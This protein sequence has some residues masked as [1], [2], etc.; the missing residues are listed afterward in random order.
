MSN[1]E[2]IAKNIKDE[3]EALLGYVPLLNDSDE[4]IREVVGEIV[5]DELNHLLMLAAIYSKITGIKPAKDGLSEA[6]AFRKPIPPMADSAIWSL[7]NPMEGLSTS[8]F[9]PVFFCSSCETCDL[10]SVR[11]SL[12]AAVAS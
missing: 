6:L 8:R 2:E 7:P 3:G 4:N 11:Y 1:I 5:G 9:M 12:A 10:C